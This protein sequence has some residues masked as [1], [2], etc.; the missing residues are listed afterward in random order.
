MESIYVKDLKGSLDLTSFKYLLHTSNTTITTQSQTNGAVVTSLA[1]PDGS[2]NAGDAMISS[3]SQTCKAFARLFDA[4]G[5]ATSCDESQ[6][7]VVMHTVLA[8]FCYSALIKLYPRSI[9]F[10][11]ELSFPQGTNPITAVSFVPMLYESFLAQ[12]AVLTSYRPSAAQIPTNTGAMNQAFVAPEQLVD[13]LALRNVGYDR[14]APS[15]HV[16]AFDFMMKALTSVDLYFGLNCNDAADLLKGGEVVANWYGEHGSRQRTVSPGGMI[17]RKISLTSGFH[18]FRVRH[19]C[20]ASS[21]PQISVMISSDGQNWSL[22][23][24]KLLFFHPQYLFAKKFSMPVG[25]EMS[26]WVDKLV[27]DQCTGAKAMSTRAFFDKFL[28]SD[29][30]YGRLNA[31]NSFPGGFIATG[32]VMARASLASLQKAFED[33]NTYGLFD[34]TL[35]KQVSAAYSFSNRFSDAFS[36]LPIRNEGAFNRLVMFSMMPLVHFRAILAIMKVYVRRRDTAGAAK[37][38]AALYLVFTT[39]LDYAILQCAGDPESANKCSNIR[40]MRKVVNDC[41]HN[42]NQT[43]GQDAMAMLRNSGNQWGKSQASIERVLRASTRQRMDVSG[44]SATSTTAHID[45]G[46]KTLLTI[47]LCVAIILLVGYNAGV[48]MWPKLGLDN[49]NAVLNNTWFAQLPPWV[50]HGVVCSA[51]VVALILYTLRA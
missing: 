8:L 3:I 45:H 7:L 32:A 43:V 16:F 44:M 41:L 9:D 12:G 13:P 1:F 14:D 2:S 20:K 47:G 30:D 39:M 29:V 22:L 50:I 17:S 6:L 5:G 36:R 26:D 11:Q 38:K 34:A 40:A 25:L 24:S 18:S 27:M 19:F 10:S 35:G 42:L 49:N 37:A 46:R 15:T 31:N 33:T 23:S 4:A 48:L 28:T 21:N 51:S